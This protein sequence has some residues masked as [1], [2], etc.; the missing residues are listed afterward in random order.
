MSI[1]APRTSGT[2]GKRG[3]TTG[4][5][6]TVP[7]GDAGTTAGVPR[8]QA[9]RHNPTHTTWSMRGPTGRPHW[10]VISS[11]LIGRQTPVQSA[12]GHFDK[13]FSQCTGA[14]R[15]GSGTKFLDFPQPFDPLTN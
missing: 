1:A 15:T 13:D 4:T 3:V 8:A 12:N 11:K 2:A 9:L 5:P 6:P 7:A 10:F 14:D